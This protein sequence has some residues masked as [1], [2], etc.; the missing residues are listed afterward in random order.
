MSQHKNPCISGHDIY[1]FGTL[2]LGH[3]LYILSLYDLFKTSGEYTLKRILQ[4][5]FIYPKLINPW[6]GGGGS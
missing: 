6:E 5:Y 3:H 1:Y 4:F 2:S